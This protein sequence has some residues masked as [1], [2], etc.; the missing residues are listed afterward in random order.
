MGR[1]VGGLAHQLI[2]SFL[3]IVVVV[4]N[5]II[6][7]ASHWNEYTALALYVVNTCRA[8]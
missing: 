5:V 8:S 2:I 4:V 7:I 3:L 1:G 6:I